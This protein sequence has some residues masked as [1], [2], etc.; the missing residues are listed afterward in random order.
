MPAKMVKLATG[1]TFAANGFGTWKD[2][3]GQVG[4]AVKAALEV[5]YRHIACA[6]IYTN[7]AEVDAVFTELFGGDDPKIRREDVWITSEVWN[8]CGSKDEVVAACRQ[9]LAD[10]KLE[11]FDEYLVHFPAVWDHEGLPITEKTALRGQMGSCGARITR[12]RTS[13]RGWR[14]AT[15]WG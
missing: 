6:A 13:G 11:Y 10:L 8:T 5:G 4:A 12:C 14:S 15:G 1:A 2:E 3:P 9:S 7:E